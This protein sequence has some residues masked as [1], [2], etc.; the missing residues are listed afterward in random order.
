MLVKKDI[1]DK[2]MAEKLKDMKGFRN[3]LIHRY[4]DVED[5]RVYHHLTTCIGDFEDF[6]KAIKSF[7]VNDKSV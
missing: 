3:I 4:G 1:L 5:R 2:E 7:L 6:E